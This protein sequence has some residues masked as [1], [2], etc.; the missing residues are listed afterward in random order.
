LTD[1]GGVGACEPFLLTTVDSSKRFNLQ[2]FKGRRGHEKRNG[3][4]SAPPVVKKDPDKGKKESNSHRASRTKGRWRDAGGIWLEHGVCA[5][6]HGVLKVLQ[7]TGD[8]LEILGYGW[9]RQM[10]GSAH[11]SLNNSGMVQWCNGE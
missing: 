6:L 7:G 5:L 11:D 9:Y 2:E 10:I 4:F 1:S 8:E 3:S